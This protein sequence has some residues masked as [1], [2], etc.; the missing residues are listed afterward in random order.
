M[1]GLFALLARKSGESVGQS[2]GYSPW[3]RV[4][5]CTALK[6]PFSH[7][8]SSPLRPHFSMFQFFK[9]PFSTKITNFTKFATL[10]PKFM[11]NF[12]SKA[13]NLTKIQFF[14]PYFFPKFSSLSPIFFPKNQFFKPLF[15]V[16]TRSLS[17]HLRP[18]GP[19]TYTKM[20]VEYPPG[21]IFL[22]FFFKSWMQKKCNTIHVFAFLGLKLILVLKGDC[23]FKKTFWDS[24]KKINILFKN[25]FV[26]NTKL[27]MKKKEKSRPFFPNILGRSEKGKQTSFFF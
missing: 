27:S 9:I 10:E 5:G 20:K 1:N 22:F 3:K 23:M 18:Y 11:Q 7:S 15:L 17:P 25:I 2:W 26:K 16:P 19:H 4:Q 24:N 8:L 6:T 13:S 14:K 21:S 12:R